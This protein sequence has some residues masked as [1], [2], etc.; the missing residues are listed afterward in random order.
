MNL[1]DQLLNNPL[2]DWVIALGLTI[3]TYVFLRI[4]RR[5]INRKLAKLAAK[6]DT[7]IDDLVSDVLAGTRS[8]FLIAV[9]AKVGSLVLDLPVSATQIIGHIV[10]LAVFIQ[11]GIWVARGVSFILTRSM[12]EGTGGDPA[13][14]TMLTPMLFITRLVVWAVILLLA[15]DNVGVDVTALITGLGIGGIAVALALQTILGDLFAS[16]AI[17]LDKPFVIGDFITVADFSGT[18]EHVGL[19]TTRVR[20]LT[21]E[22]IVIGNSDLLNSRIRNF[23]RMEERRALFVVGVTYQTPYEKLRRIP[24]MIKEIIVKDP[25]ARFDRCHFKEFAASSLNFET[26]YFVLAPDYISY[27]ERQQAINLEVYRRFE[28]EGIEFAY[29]TQTLYLEKGE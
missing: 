14:V 22:Q 8:F 17:V 3:F 26:V 25:V 28:A 11:T 13:S 21:G 20:S 2:S 7:R 1:T 9:S 27:M 18:I 5:L 6:T 4:A 12:R 19:K 29:P 16:L 15:L 10:V 24:E 23:K